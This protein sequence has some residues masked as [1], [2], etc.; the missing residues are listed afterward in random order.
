[1]GTTT[2]NAAIVAAGAN[3]AISV[4]A[5]NNNDA[6]I[7]VN[8]YFAPAD[9]GGLSLFTLPPCRV[10]DTRNGG[11][12]PL[13]GSLSVNVAGS[14][15]GAPST[16]K[17]YVL[18]ATV[19][20]QGPLGFLTLWASNAPQPPVSTLNAVDGVVTSNMAIVPAAN[21][22]VNAFAANPTH[23]VLDILGYFSN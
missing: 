13:N 10:L 3:G 17:A 8:G 20:P 16:A 6:V 14:N 23:L 9:Q 11:G 2:A 7:D 19:I 15:C 5:S 1:M 4:L 21:G 18:S 22:S 12:G